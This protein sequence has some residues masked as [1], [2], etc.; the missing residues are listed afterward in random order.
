MVLVIALLVFLFIIANTTLAVLVEYLNDFIPGFGYFWQILSLVVSL[1]LVTLLLAAM[2]TILPDAKIAWQ[3]TLVGAGITTTLFMLG[4]FLFSLFLRQTDLGSAY[5]VAGSLVI[6]IT[7]IYYTAHILFL[8]AEFTK[9]Y[10][11][12]RG[13]PIVPAEYAIRVSQE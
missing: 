10:A 3:N 2:F 1:A 11:K 12:R 8:G 7:W 5:G 4:Q 9:V 6:V 13:A